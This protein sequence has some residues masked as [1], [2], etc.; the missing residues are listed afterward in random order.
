VNSK[1][2]FAKINCRMQC[3]IK[4]A[5]FAFNYWD[6]LEK[7][8]FVSCLYSLLIICWDISCLCACSSWN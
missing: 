7:L 4:V 3:T 8:S 2:V 6:T 5:K 1:E